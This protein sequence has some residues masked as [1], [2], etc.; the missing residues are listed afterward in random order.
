[1][2]KESLL[3]WVLKK[4]ER[5]NNKIIDLIYQQDQTD[6]SRGFE[7]ILCVVVYFFSIGIY[8]EYKDVLII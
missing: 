8:H 2:S 5:Y 1:M 7:D 3:I 6:R 4:N